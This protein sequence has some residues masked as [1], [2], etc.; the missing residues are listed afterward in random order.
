MEAMT[1]R[2]KALLQTLA[3]LVLL[4]IALFGAAGRLDVSEFWIYIAVLAAVSAVALTI[5]D[6]DLMAERMRPGG[7]RV[8]WHFFPLIAFMFLHWVVAGLD[9]GRW[10]LGDALPLDL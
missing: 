9:R 5:L 3:F 1:V 6:S 7:Q 4:G 8:G 2:T 10:H